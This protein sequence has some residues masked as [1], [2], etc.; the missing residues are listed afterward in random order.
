MS[1]VSLDDVKF[2][3]FTYT[4][5]IYAACEQRG[6]R[7]CHQVCSCMKKKSIKKKKKEVQFTAQGKRVKHSRKQQEDVYLHGGSHQVTGTNG[8]SAKISSMG[9]KEKSG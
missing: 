3:E 9:K 2:Y 1:F 5:D 4:A 8:A 7:C 6:W